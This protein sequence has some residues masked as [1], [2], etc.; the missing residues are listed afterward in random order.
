[1]IFINICRGPGV[2]SSPCATAGI[3]AAYL[4][5]PRISRQ[6]AQSIQVPYFRTGI[7]WLSQLSARHRMQ[8][9]TRPGSDE[10]GKKK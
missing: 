10:S 5:N 3:A 2:T 8:N 6:C 4:A 9:V 7:T 1:M